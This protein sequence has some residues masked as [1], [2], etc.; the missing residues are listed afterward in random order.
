MS[1]RD[2]YP[3]GC[4]FASAAAELDTRMG[5]VRDRAVAVV[6]NWLG[7]QQQA[8]RDAQA[9]G[10]IDASEDLEQLAFE[11]EAYLM[12]ANQMFVISRDTRPIERARRALER[13]LAQAA[14]A[15]G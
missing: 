11:L 10:A 14:P 6:G 12:C 8:A 5:P 15:A 2:V 13:R 7:H 9:E 1:R 4:F 3:G